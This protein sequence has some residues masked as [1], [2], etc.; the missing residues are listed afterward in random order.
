MDK[1]ILLFAHFQGTISKPFAH[2]GSDL[3][4]SVP[5]VF[6]GQMKLTGYS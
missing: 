3:E 5:F 2:S 1:M 6:S 4:T